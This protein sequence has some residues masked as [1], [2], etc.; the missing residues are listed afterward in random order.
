[1][2]QLE[3]DPGGMKES[4]GSALGPDCRRVKDLESFKEFIE[5]RRGETGA[6]RGQIEN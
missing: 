3:Y 4:I 5:T 2:V 1:M 6:G